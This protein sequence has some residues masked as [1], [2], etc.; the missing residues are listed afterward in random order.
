MQRSHQVTSAI[1]VEG[2]HIVDIQ[3]GDITLFATA[4]D[5][6]HAQV[7][8]RFDKR[9]AIRKSAVNARENRFNAG[10]SLSSRTTNPSMT[11]I[12]YDPKFRLVS[13]VFRQCKLSCSSNASSY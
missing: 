12:M 10:L 1:S 3:A 5:R 8:S 7:R 6:Q 13:N 4:G 11:N 2:V 9:E